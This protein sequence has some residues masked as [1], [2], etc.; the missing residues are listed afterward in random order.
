MDILLTVVLPLALAFI[1]FSLGVGLTG[2]DFRRVLERPI[3][4]L[5][6]ALNQIFLL[7]LVAFACILAFGVTGEMAVG[8][9]ILAACPGGVTSNIIAKMARGDVALSV[10]LTAVISLACVVTVPLILTFAADHFLGTDAPEIDI[11]TT[12]LTMFALTVIPILLGLGVRRMAPGPV[13]RAEPV[14]SAI[15]TI[16]FAVIVIAAIAANW[17]IFVENVAL[18]G[19][20]LLTLLALLTGIGFVVP[21]LLGRSR[22]EAKTVSIETGVQNG[23]LGIAVAG[24]IVAGG[25]IISPYA[26]PSAVYG[27]FM[28]LIILP[29]LL[30]YR[31]ME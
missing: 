26:L 6:G 8:V 11:T 23:T 19:P 4:F 17:R 10:S 16:L 12:A 20:L 9:M 7:P 15:A 2:A 21:R 14:L 13:A 28:Y 18:L 3:A 24:L 1:M 30:I 22:L 5:V 27:V 29:V 25:S 31:R